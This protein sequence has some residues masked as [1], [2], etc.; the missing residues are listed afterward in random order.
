MIEQI[1]AFLESASNWLTALSV[2]I[3]FLT[4]VAMLCV[5]RKLRKGFEKKDFLTGSKK[6]IK[7][8]AGYSDSLLDGI[9]NE[10]FLDQIDACLVDVFTSYTFFSV[11]LR[12]RLWW[13]SFC[14][15]HCY[16][17][18]IK[19]ETDKYRHKLSLQ[20]RKIRILMG[21]E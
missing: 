18:E 10:K 8:I 20:L 16:K 4:L 15:N 14:I 6:I 21:K 12:I 7:E 17:K 1:N 2:I 19:E 3:S 5:N 13:T 11:K 9:Y